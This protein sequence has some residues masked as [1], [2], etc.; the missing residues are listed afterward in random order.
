MPKVT[1]E[2][3]L[4]ELQDKAEVNPHMTVLLVVDLQYESCH[5]AGYRYSGPEAMEAV[6]ASAA[7]VERARASGVRVIWLKSVRTPDQPIFTVY[8]HEPY[9][10]DGTWNVEI[11]PPLEPLPDEPVIKKRTHNCFIDTGLADHLRAAGIAGPVWTFVVV[12]VSL[13]SCVMEA[14]KGLSNRD[15]RVLV[16][17]D[18]VAPR[19]GDRAAVARYQLGQSTYKYNVATL[20]SSSVIAFVEPPGVPE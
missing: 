10:I 9:R 8:G 16:P 7:L 4:P 15:F 3:D 11:V 5:P 20:T 2:L 6:H 12:G 18:C 1:V 17:M 19:T 14:V 13:T